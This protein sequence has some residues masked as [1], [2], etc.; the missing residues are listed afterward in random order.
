MCHK[1]E[2]RSFV[3]AWVLG[4]VACS[5]SAKQ[6][7]IGPVPSPQTTGT[8]SGPLCRDQRCTCADTEAAAGVP[9][10][11]RKRFEV[12]LKSAQALWLSMPGDTQLYKD[13]ETAESCFYVDLAPG[14]HAI[15]LRASNK[16]GVSAEVIVRELGAT[17]QS[18]YD[19]FRFECGNPG[20]CS[21]AELE[22]LKGHYAQFKRNL[23][24][25]CGSTK[26]KGV[27]W[28][29]GTAPDG[30][31]PSELVVR[32][33]LDVY[34]FAPWKPHGDTTCG[35][36]GGRPPGDAEPAAEPAAE[37]PAP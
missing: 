36:G 23:H 28:D 19:T 27:I 26:I 2:M 3:M 1:G 34:K 25:P 29:H 9:D 17:T 37:A 13:G 11:A 6:I 7:E 35:E 22:A 16:D 33:T 4:L 18:F 14:E 8:L 30:F 12:R 20:A 32:A 5:G 10:G 21:F 31:H 15:Q 24:D